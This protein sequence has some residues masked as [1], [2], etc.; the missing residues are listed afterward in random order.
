MKIKRFNPSKKK[1]GENVF[2]I[3]SHGFNA[4]KPLKKPIPNSWEIETNFKNAF[5]V[6]F[7]VFNSKILS[8]YIRGSVIPFLSLHEYRKIITPFLN[9]P[10]TE[11][12]NVLKKLDAIQ[13]IN[14]VI[15]QNEKQKK[16]YNEMKILLSS[17]ILKTLS[18]Q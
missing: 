2:Y 13:K 17:E 8:S 18:A 3:Q 12:E 4:G 5:E 16:I 6:C 7:V 1:E 9:N 15:E 14:F 10:L 11:N